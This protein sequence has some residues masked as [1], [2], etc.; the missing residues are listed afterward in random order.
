MNKFENWVPCPCGC[1]YYASPEAVICSLCQRQ[2]DVG[3]AFQTWCE[4]YQEC[5]EEE[6]WELLHEA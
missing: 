3:Y 1:G 5:W 6:T 4:E 2:I